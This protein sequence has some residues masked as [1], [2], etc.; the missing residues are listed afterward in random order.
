MSK[1]DDQLRKCRQALIMELYERRRGSDN[2]VQ[3]AEAIEDLICA[4]V[5]LAFA[6][7][8]VTKSRDGEGA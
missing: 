1:H 7:H 6:K 2:D 3:I 4:V 8:P 5:S